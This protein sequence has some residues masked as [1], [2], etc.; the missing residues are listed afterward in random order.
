MTTGHNIERG[1]FLGIAER[2]EREKQQRRNDIID[3]AERLFFS[4]GYG[5]TTMDQVADEAELSKGTLYLY[6][7]SKEDLYLAINVRGM[8]ILEKMFRGSQQPELSG[9]ENVENIGRAYFAFSQKHPN[10]FEAMIFYES[11]NIADSL[12]DSCIQ[13]CEEQGE[14]TLHVVAETVAAGIADGSIRNDADPMLTA[15]VLWGHSTGM[16]Q[17]LALKE[18]HLLNAHGVDAG[19]LME[20]SF[21]I[22]AKGLAAIR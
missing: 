9:L 6:F 19:T 13:S 2:K 8:K 22:T 16:I 11:K 14:R 7:K 4:R 1:L 5:S 3:A 17:I 21:K 12:E 10:Y 20:A 18:Q 15:T